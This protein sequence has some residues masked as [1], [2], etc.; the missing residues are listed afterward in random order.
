MQDRSHRPNKMNTTLMPAQEALV[1]ELRRTML[2]PPDGP[3]AITHE[4][5]N[6]EA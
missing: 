5:I 1:V 4:F 3:L 2:L 6:T